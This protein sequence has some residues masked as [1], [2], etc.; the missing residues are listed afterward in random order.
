M[1]DL[2]VYKI[3]LELYIGILVGWGCVAFKLIDPAKGHMEGISFYLGK[4][5]LPLVV[6]GDAAVINFSN[7]QF[8]VI[9]ACNAAKIV[10][11]V[12][13]ALLCYWF[14]D[15][16]NGRRESFRTAALFGFFV[17]SSNDFLI[18]FPLFNAVFATSDLDACAYLT[19]N[20]V[21]NVAFFVPVTVVLLEISADSCPEEGERRSKAKRQIFKNIITNP[22]LLAAVLGL[23]YA[24]FLN[25]GKSTELPFGLK[26]VVALLTGPFTMLALFMTGASIKFSRLSAWPFVLAIM[27]VVGVA[28][29]GFV[30]TA[31]IFPVFGMGKGADTKEFGR[32]TYIYGT[33]PTSSAPLVLAKISGVDENTQ[34]VMAAAIL[35]SILLACPSMIAGNVFVDPDHVTKVM[36]FL[37]VNISYMSTTQLLVTTCLLLKL[38]CPCRRR[39][40]NIDL[41]FSRSVSLNGVQLAPQESEPRYPD[42][43]TLPRS[44]SGLELLGAGIKLAVITSYVFVLLLYTGFSVELLE[45]GCPA[46][47]QQSVH[48]WIFTVLQNICR[49]FPLLLLYFSRRSWSLGRSQCTQCA[50]LLCVVSILLSCIVEPVVFDHICATKFKPL[51]YGLMLAY[52]AAL[53]IMY[54]VGLCM[55]YKWASPLESTGR[56]VDPGRLIVA[57]ASFQ[58]FLLLMQCLN[59]SCMILRGEVLMGLLVV[60]TCLD[61]GQGILLFLLLIQ[62]GDVKK[63]LIRGWCKCCRS[64]DSSL[65]ESPDEPDLLQF[66]APTF[67][68]VHASTWSPQ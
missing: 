37:Q 32:L 22:L 14:Y 47:A 66:C 60:E 43:P 27:K 35:I 38:G 31:W 51:S 24:G 33:L 44:A 4:I 11:A 17:T 53:L 29:W 5:A 40:L 8:A 57:C 48:A 55:H 9:I 25:P 42:I 39:S 68:S 54:V 13:T 49:G 62:F 59:L 3:I 20:A 6:F 34:Q 28:S 56:D 63:T 1:A 2:E 65:L 18:G 58:G 15:P 61:S 64:A 19:V 36:F 52:A 46:N 23:L 12:C 41:P 16:G 30:F 7:L 10:A 26:D 67:G 50:V 45:L 21:I